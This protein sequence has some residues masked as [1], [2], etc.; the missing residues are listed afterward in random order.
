MNTR[1]SKEIAE[2]RHLC[3]LAEARVASGNDVE[4]MHTMHDIARQAAETIRIIN[5]ED[6]P[7]PSEGE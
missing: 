1:I 7:W 6:V 2:I 3:T 4:A 5:E